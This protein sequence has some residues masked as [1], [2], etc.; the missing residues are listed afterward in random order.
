[1]VFKETAEITRALAQLIHSAEIRLASAL[2]V[3]E[4]PMMEGAAS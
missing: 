2:A 4:G 3:V 1:M